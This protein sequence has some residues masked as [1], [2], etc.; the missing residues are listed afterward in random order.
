MLKL[1]KIRHCDMDQ[2]AVGVR[3]DAISLKIMKPK[4]ASSTSIR[5]IKL[6]MYVTT[7]I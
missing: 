2:I 5:R 6:F 7:K 3:R 1:N 4:N